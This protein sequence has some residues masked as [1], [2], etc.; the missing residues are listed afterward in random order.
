MLITYV[1]GKYIC[2]EERKEEEKTNIYIYIY[3]AN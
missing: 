2:A 3:F 1:G